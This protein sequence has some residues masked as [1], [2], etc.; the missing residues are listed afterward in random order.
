MFSISSALPCSVVVG[1]E[2]HK[3]T[4]RPLILQSEYSA[5]T[6]AVSVFS[7]E[8]D[9]HLYDSSG[10]NTFQTRQPESGFHSCQFL[11]KA[12]TLFC[13][14]IVS[15]GLHYVDHVELQIGSSFDTG[16]TL[17][18]PEATKVDEKELEERMQKILSLMGRLDQKIAPM[19]EAD[20]Q[21]F[22]PK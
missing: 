19:L 10:R 21:H 1:A 7:V 5:K 6:R 9:N 20:G 14:R 12:S 3:Y 17:Q 2:Q 13:R 18:T 4:F 8:E 22:N 11:A 16:N 15:I